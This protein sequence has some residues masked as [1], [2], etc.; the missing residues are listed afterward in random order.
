MLNGPRMIE[1]LV[2]LETGGDHDKLFVLR[3]DL[4]KL[5][6]PALAERYQ[7]KTGKDPYDEQLSKK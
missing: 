4:H 3:R 5:S 2:S 1:T 7:A 6:L